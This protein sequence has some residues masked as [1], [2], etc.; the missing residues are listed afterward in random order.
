MKKMIKISSL[1]VLVLL[2]NSCASGYKKINPEKLN[3]VSKSIENN[4]LL[5]YK[6]D[7][8]EKKYRKKET[9]NNVKLIA[10][11]I[12][13]NSGKDLVFGTDFTLSFENG[14]EV[15]ILETEKLYTTIKQSPAS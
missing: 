9:N 3:Y 2:L 5:E 6:Y 12:K 10:V 7:L 11:K 4:I 8:L 13:N 1:L 14:N 15:S